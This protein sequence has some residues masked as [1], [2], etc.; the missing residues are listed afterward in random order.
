M[1]RNNDKSLDFTCTIPA[2]YRLAVAA[3]L[4]K[5]LKRA[6][7][8]G[9][10]GLLTYEISDTYVVESKS[11]VDEVP[12]KKSFIDVTVNGEVP[13][14][15]GWSFIGKLT[16]D[17]V[18]DFVTVLAAPDMEVPAKFRK[19]KGSCDHC[20]TDRYRKDTFVISKK[21]K[22]MEIGRSCLKDFFPTVNI[23]WIVS[24]FKYVN[25]MLKGGDFDGYYEDNG[26][27]KKFRPT[28]NLELILMV[29]N[30]IIRESGW[31][32][33]TAVKK[34]RENNP[35]A[36]VSA[37]SWAVESVVALKCGLRSKYKNEEELVL[38]TKDEE[39]AP[40]VIDFVRNEMY[41]D[42]DYVYNMKNFFSLDDA[43]LRYIP[44]IASAI[45][46]Y[47]RSLE[48]EAENKVKK[49][50]SNYVGTV[51]EKITSD[52]EVTGSK[53]VKGFY[54]SSLLVK[55]VDDLGN[56]FTT[57]YSGYK[58]EPE[59]GDKLTIKGTVKAH[60]EFKGWKSTMLTRVTVV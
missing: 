28:A 57:F 45:P 50:V 48:K 41:G 38:T 12:I 30:A 51:G 47:T 7:K 3:K 9:L 49:S 15:D 40:K 60:K 32:S 4:D 39:I 26:R 25:D 22:F 23:E 35:D 59:I 13:K 29:T 43:D 56:T 10:D 5:I 2:G 19:S 42:N 55:M 14:I 27:N 46:A 20:K 16:H 24:Y 11:K 1:M 6:S 8:K 21:G 33:G 44:F 58:F 31:M 36:N 37:T 18:G 53:Y 34:I 17:G 52:V 54:G